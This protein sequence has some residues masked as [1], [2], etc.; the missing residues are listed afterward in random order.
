MSLGS[1]FSSYLPPAL[2][3][4]FS[5][6]AVH[7]ESLTKDIRITRLRIHPIKSCR[8][9]EVDSVN[10]DKSRLFPVADTK[11]KV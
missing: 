6:K 5:T 8:G 4:A 10:Y 11:L 1:T 7:A 3:S 2:T 9:L